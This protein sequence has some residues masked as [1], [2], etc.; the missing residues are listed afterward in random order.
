VTPEGY[1]K[2]LQHEGEI[3]HGYFDA[4]GYMTVGVGHLIDPRRGGSITRQVSRELFEDDISIATVK[5]RVAFPWFDYLDAIRQDAIVNLTFNLGIDGLL[6][7][8][9]ML[10]AIEQ[11]DWGK[12]AYELFN[13]L[14][15][16]QV[17][18][19]RVDDL[20]RALEKGEWH[21]TATRRAV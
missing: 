6:K 8:H 2:L 21:E 12:A 5:A 10:G 4:L 15:R 13:S 7:F 1:V 11:Q 16:Q 20:M 18:K 14:W 19:Q 17:Q 3:L 9:N